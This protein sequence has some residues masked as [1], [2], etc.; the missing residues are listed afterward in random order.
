MSTIVITPKD[1]SSRSIESCSEIS[2]PADKSIFHRILMLAALSESEVSIPTIGKLSSDIQTTLNALIQ[3]GVKIDQRDKEIIVYGVGKTG[4]QK[5]SKPIDCRNSG[6]TARLL[7]GILASQSFESA[8]I[9]DD[10][11]TKR[12]MSRLAKILNEQL[13]ADILCS[14]TGTL[15]VQIR[16]KVLHNAS[17]ILP[18]ASAQIKSSVLLAAY[19]SNTAIKISE[20]EKSRDHTEKMML[21]MG[22]DL[23]IDANS[24][25]LEANRSLQIPQAY[26]YQIPGDLSSAAFFAVASA[27]TKINLTIRNVGLNATRSRFFETLNAAGVPIFYEKVAIVNGELYGDVIIHG[28][29][30]SQLKPFT[31]GAEDIPNLQDEIPALTVFALFTNGKSTIAGATE[32]RLK[33]S[34]RIHAMANN[35]ER[36]GGRVTELPDGLEITGSSTFIPSGATIDSYG[37]HRI[38]MAMAVAALKS[39]GVVT[40]PNASVV[41]ISFPTFFELLGCIPAASMISITEL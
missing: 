3:L 4:L 11:L 6:T 25:S 31:L 39:S 12:P 33:E 34:D 7:M 30:I 35:L 22:I 14:D 23:Q 40:I 10:S 9:G 21:S 16:G 27:I 13:G 2:V 20:P 38:A 37:D 24:V 28:S 15:P 36:I 29:R 18:F 41:S 19:C 5:P 17:V 32:L 1:N 8:L 26:S